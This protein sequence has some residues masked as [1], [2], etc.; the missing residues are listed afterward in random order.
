M[1]APIVNL[2]AGVVY[3]AGL[4][5]C[6]ASRATKCRG[7]TSSP[8][9]HRHVALRVVSPAIAGEPPTILEVRARWSFTSEERI[10]GSIRDDQR[11]YLGLL[12]EHAVTNASS[13]SIARK[14]SGECYVAQS[15]PLGARHGELLPSI[16]RANPR[17]NFHTQCRVRRGL[18]I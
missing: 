9:A 15:A 5:I 1:E 16:H 2:I 10:A 14:I 4:E 7:V 12:E 8:R 17:L 6:I 18:G 13:S 11:R 3:V